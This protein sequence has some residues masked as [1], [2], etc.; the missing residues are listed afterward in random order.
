MPCTSEAEQFPLRRAAGKDLSAVGSVAS[1]F[2]S[3]IDTEVDARLAAIGTDEAAALRGTAAIANARLTYE[4][5]E[6][7]MGTDRWKHLAAAGA[8][9]QRLLWASTGVKDPAYSD[10]RYVDELVAPATVNTMPEATLEAVADHGVVTGNV[11]SGMYAEARVVI[12]ALARLGIDLDDV[13]KVLEAD[14]VGKFQASWRDLQ[15]EVARAL[16]GGEQA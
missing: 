16:Q 10:T 13:V 15:A 9:P 2:V 12:D 6:R 14:G 11:V 3:R 5:F 7:V 4:V 1:V 8:Q